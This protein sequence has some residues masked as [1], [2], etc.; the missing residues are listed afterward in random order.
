[1]NRESESFRRWEQAGLEGLWQVKVVL[2]HLL[3]WSLMHL[4]LLLLKAVITVA[5]QEIWLTSQLDFIVL[6]GCSG[7]SMVCTR[8]YCL[9]NCR[10]AKRERR[11][12]F[13]QN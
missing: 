11:F 2:F 1:M 12:V 13:R 8:V 4:L 7:L 3:W 9:G 6:L 10:V 5:L